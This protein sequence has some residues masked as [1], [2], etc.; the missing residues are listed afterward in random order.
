MLTQPTTVL[1]LYT[2]EPNNDSNE[3]SLE[4]LLI[5]NEETENLNFRLNF[6]RLNH[7]IHDDVPELVDDESDNDDDHDDDQM[8]FPVR[9]YVAEKVIIHKDDAVFM[10]DSGTQATFLSLDHTR[11]CFNRRK[12][13]GSII[14]AAG[15]VMNGIS[16]S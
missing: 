5:E 6:M 9:V 1:G 10:A 13:S 14:T 15:E 11:L 12:Q 7:A 2:D 3:K 16:T 8:T 4:D